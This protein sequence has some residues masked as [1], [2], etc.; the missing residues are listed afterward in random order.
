MAT[1]HEQI[2]DQSRVVQDVDYQRLENDIYY[3]KTHNI[4]PGITILPSRLI[5]LVS[6]PASSS[7]LPSCPTATMR[8]PRTAIASAISNRR[9]TVTIFPDRNIKSGGCI[10]PA[11]SDCGNIASRYVATKMIVDVFI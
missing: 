3:L 4:K 10:C 11:N 1:I 5:T 6:G 9:L 7:T 2:L 8:S